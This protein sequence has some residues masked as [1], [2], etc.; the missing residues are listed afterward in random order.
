MS[1]KENVLI[2]DR[3]SDFNSVISFYEETAELI[4]KLRPNITMTELKDEFESLSQYEK[5]V[6]AARAMV[7]SESLK[8][9]NIEEILSKYRIGNVELERM[10]EGIDF[11]DKF[12]L[13]NSNDKKQKIRQLRNCLAHA[14]YEIKIVNDSKIYIHI[15]NGYISGDIEI[16]E[17][18]ELIKSYEN[19]FDKFM[20]KKLEK[21]GVLY[22]DEKS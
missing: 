10:F 5:I 16:N 22:F 8:L 9:F 17:F 19:V 14:M 2:L 6:F 18:I 7:V 13:K 3:I 12:Q 11:L 20:E 21:L 4:T 15:N 1:D